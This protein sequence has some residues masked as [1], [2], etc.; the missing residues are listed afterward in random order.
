MNFN[1]YSSPP[2]FNTYLIQALEVLN[3]MQHSG[4]NLAVG[5]LSYFYLGEAG[6]PHSPDKTF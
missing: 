5:L 1:L 2:S 6:E 4:K 3:V